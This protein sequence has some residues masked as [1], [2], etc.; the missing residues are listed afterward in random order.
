M[1]KYTYK[2]LITYIDKLKKI[3]SKTDIKLSDKVL[4]AISAS[5]GI[6]YGLNQNYIDLEAER[7]LLKL[8]SHFYISN[9]NDTTEGEYVLFYDG[10]GFDNR[11]LALEYLTALIEKQYKIVYITVAKNASLQNSI[12]KLLKDN[13]AIIINLPHQLSYI[14]R[15]KRIVEIAN[16]H[17]Y[18][19]AFL[20]ARPQD[21]SAILAFN[22]MNGKIRRYQ[23]NLTDHA[24]WLGLN[25]FDYCIEFR[26]YGAS[27]SHHYRNV[28]LNK[29]LE[30]PYYPY[31]EPDIKL[32]SLPFSLNGRK[33]IVSGGAL[34]KTFDASNTYYRIISSILKKHTDTLFY[35]MGYGDTSKLD[36]LEKE[37][38]GRVFFSKERKDFFEILKKS[39]LYINSY[40]ISGALMLQYA[41]KAECIPMVLRREWDEDACGMLLNEDKINN[42]FTDIEKFYNRIDE[43]ITN[44]IE[45]RRTKS[46]LKNSVIT[47]NQFA[48][49]L[50]CIIKNPHPAFDECLEKIDT[51]KFRDA[52]KE[53]IQHNEIRGYIAN[54]SN[55]S[56]AIKYPYEFMCFVLIK[57]KSIIS[58]RMT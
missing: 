12:T 23:I 25:A 10:F 31:I 49:Q 56:L 58:R 38:P 17:K 57:L 26:K 36:E 55:M 14:N 27:I 32:D 8:S 37:F 11:G 16:S 5:A 9:T 53:N 52:Y 18:E 29:L 35:Y 41:A 1:Y 54:K 40:P 34:Y 2:K 44:D 30:L 28:D 24:F 3:Y 22:S 20:Y 13:N 51:S 7:T 19:C 50:D 47:N 6:Q 48:Y 43:L 45:Y 15:T 21:V 39:Y 4:S 33:L 46:I 42:V